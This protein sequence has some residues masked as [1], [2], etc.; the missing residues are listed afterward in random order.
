MTG[1]CEQLTQ[2]IVTT[3]AVP[4]SVGITD[5]HVPSNNC[6]FVQT[7][8]KTAPFRSGNPALAAKAGAGRRKTAFCVAMMC[9]PSSIRRGEL[10][11]ACIWATGS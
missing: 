4:R 7:A 11:R 1:I 10:S 2:T 8:H 6:L 3:M 9:P 5:H